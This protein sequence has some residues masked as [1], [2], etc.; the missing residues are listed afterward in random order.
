MNAIVDNQ[1]PADV[2]QL[3]AAPSVPVIRAPIVAT[4]NQRIGSLAKKLLSL[5]RDIAE[6]RGESRAKWEDASTDLDS[7]LHEAEHAASVL[8]EKLNGEAREAE[9][10]RDAKDWA[11]TECSLRTFGMS[12]R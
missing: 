3:L 1:L 6:L 7:I 8:D 12:V 2:A 5:E 9:A 4:L 10:A 11:E